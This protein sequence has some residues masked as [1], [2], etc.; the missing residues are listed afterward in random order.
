[1]SSKS[2]SPSDLC[3]ASE[4]SSEDELLPFTQ[5]DYEEYS[6][7]EPVRAFTH[8]YNRNKGFEDKS[9]KDNNVV[10]TLLKQ[11]E[12]KRLELETKQKQSK[13]P[14]EPIGPSHASEPSI[15][16]S[17]VC[18]QLTIPSSSLSRE[19]HLKFLQLNTIAASNPQLLG[20]NDRKNFH[21]LRERVQEEK[22]AYM[23]WLYDRAKERFQHLDKKVDEAVEGY[24]TIERERIIKDYPRYYEF[25]N[26]FDLTVGLPDARDPILVHKQTLHEAG[27]CFQF[28]L[29]MGTASK[30]IPTH[31]NY[32]LSD[33]TE[34]INSELVSDNQTESNTQTNSK[35]HDDKTP[36]NR[37]QKYI[38]PVVSTDPLIPAMVEQ[39]SVDIV[40]SSS[41][42]CALVALHAS[43][44]RDCN[45]PICVISRRNASGEMKKTVYIDKPFVKKKM[46]NRERNQIFY[47]AAFKSVA[48]DTKHTFEK[49]KESKSSFLTE[50]QEF[51]DNESTLVIFNEELQE[52]TPSN[53]STKS[54]FSEAANNNKP[55]ERDETLKDDNMHDIVDTRID[56]ESKNGQTTLEKG[57][58]HV[59]IT[60]NLWCFGE[61]SIL[62]RCKMHGF[63][64]D[65]I[66][67]PR[68]VGI[69]TN[70]EYQLDLGMEE[71][72]AADRARYWIHTYIRGDADLMLGRIDVLNSEIQAVERKKMINIIP[73]GNWP[74]PHSKF[75]YT[76]LKNFQSLPD[77]NYLFSHV[78]GDLH[79]SVYKSIIKD[80]KE[81]PDTTVSTSQSRI[82]DLHAA[83]SVLAIHDIE[84][85][86]FVPLKWNGPSDQIPFT[87]PVRQKPYYCYQYAN[88]GFCTR[89]QCTFQHI[90]KNEINDP[91]ILK[92]VN[93][94][95][96]SD[97][98]SGL[99]G[100]IQKTEKPTKNQKRKKAKSKKKQKEQSNASIPQDLMTAAAAATGHQANEFVHLDDPTVIENSSQSAFEYDRP[101]SNPL[102]AS[103][104]VWSTYRAS[105][106]IGARARNKL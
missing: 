29:P 103:L 9:S 72:A 74:R 12:E 8:W 58:R 46:T 55:S 97:D 57:L 69:K 18:Q 94:H 99:P 79:A 78:A 88:Y 19:E 51:N 102:N 28:T 73:N 37:W 89:E 17:S 38:M 25:L 39:N 82:Y 26:A 47:D 105:R 44:E 31:E 49:K 35:I 33:N 76:M 4:E 6:V 43:T 64:F 23:K 59:N 98:T 10:G 96:L 22:N 61:F 100:K 80:N 13:P 20:D 50:D 3:I 84:T 77:G 1:M 95:K 68:I 16:P 7:Y 30:K 14:P 62:I 71:I 65:S 48:M 93:T 24:L 2:D 41:G 53:Q 27:A 34:T 81:F 11:L 106:K 85:V 40:I 63:V 91:Q 104:N 87:F 36:G 86:H 5:E 83:Y 32:L 70:L 45:I 54:T 42:L 67:K 15:K 92:R 56:S 75:L 52:Q 90:P 66:N 60:Y 21:Y 101:R